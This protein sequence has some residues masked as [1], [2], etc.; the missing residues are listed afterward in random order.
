MK[1]SSLTS[2]S[3]ERFGREYI[4]QCITFLLGGDIA[5]LHRTY[6]ETRERIMAHQLEVRD[7]ARIESLSDPPGVYREAVEA[8]KRQ[9]SAAYEVAMRMDRDVRRGYRVA[10][11]ITG[12][13]P[14]PKGFR[15]ARPVSEWNPNFPDEN[16]QYYL[17]RLDEFSEKFKPYFRPQDFRRIFSPD[18][19]FP[20]STEGIAIMA[21]EAI[22]IELQEGDETDEE[23]EGPA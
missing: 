1:G 10:Y 16:V 14:N 21:P 2:R 6:V 15:E 5:A 18:D 11:Y 23:P 19:L 7:F 20:F 9:R 12:D 13:D 17:R 3:I 22:E 4:R 8:G